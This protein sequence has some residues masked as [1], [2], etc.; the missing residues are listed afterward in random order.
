M[1]EE[2]GKERGRLGRGLA[3]PDDLKKN[4]LVLLMVQTLS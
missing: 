1:Y 4:H 3:V 2:R